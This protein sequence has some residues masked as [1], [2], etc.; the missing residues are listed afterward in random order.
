MAGGTLTRY[1]IF[2]VGGNTTRPG[3]PIGEDFSMM[4]VRKWMAEFLVTSLL[5]FPNSV[6]AASADV[7]SWKLDSG[8]SRIGFTGQQAGAKFEGQFSRFSAVIAF[9]PDH[10]EAS[11]ISVTVD[12]ASAATGDP[13]RDAALPGSD[14]F[15]VSHFPQAKFESA[16]V[17]RKE[18][19]AY[20]AAGTL[21][22]RGITRPV[23]LR[24]TIIDIKDGFAHAKGH[25]EL[26]R[27]DFGVG[28]GSWRS[29][30]WVALE[31]GV[32]FDIVASR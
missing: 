29:A 21:T 3:D 25:T 14:W 12:L 8:K 19:G 11:R 30:Q 9:D 6:S 26:V 18:P 2:P 27:G 24:F 28:H 32:D 4:I 16:S 15:D 10:P 5:I 17:L 7:P 31:V 1:G 22:L 13:K 20:E 23:L